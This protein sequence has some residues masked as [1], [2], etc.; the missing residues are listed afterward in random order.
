MTL[1][2]GWPRLCRLIRATEWDSIEIMQQQT[3][4]FEYLKLAPDAPAAQVE[5]SVERL[6][7]QAAALAVTQPERSQQLRDNV[8]AIKRDLMSGPENRARYDAARAAAD[9]KDEATTGVQAKA[10]E[11]GVLSARVVRLPHANHYVFL[12]NEADVLREM[13]GFLANLP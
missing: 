7:R 10:F 5:Q 3:D 6:S 1:P 2:T 11:S 13:N 12:S 9:A 4:W 8:R